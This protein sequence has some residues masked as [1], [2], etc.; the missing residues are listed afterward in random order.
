KAKNWT[1]F[2]K[3]LG[4]EKPIGSPFQI[5]YPLSDE[6]PTPPEPLVAMHDEPK[7]CNDS[8][9]AYACSCLDCVEACPKLPAWEDEKACHV[10]IIPC[11]SFSVLV[12]YASFLTAILFCYGYLF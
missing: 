12:I 11:L 6:N 4:D 3:F 9:P 8:D 7:K 5:D 10:G 1:A 2:L